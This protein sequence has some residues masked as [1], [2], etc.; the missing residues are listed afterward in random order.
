MAE[1]ELTPEAL[2]EKWE[3][4]RRD[5]GV[6]DAPSPAPAATTSEPTSNEASAVCVDCGERFTYESVRGFT[7]RPLFRRN[8]CDSCSEA[9]EQREQQELRDA[10]IAAANREAEEHQRA[11]AKRRATVLDLLE[12]CGV[13]TREHGGAAL[14][15]FDTSES[16]DEPVAAARAFLADVR[17]AGRHDPVRGL[18]LWGPTGAGKSTLAVAVLRELLL[19][20]SQRTDRMLFDHAAE[21]IAR[22]QGTY[23]GSG[24]T[25]DVLDRRSDAYLWILDDLGTER[26]SEDVMRHLTLI[27]TRRALR[28]T[29]VTSNL[30]PRHLDAERP[31]LSRVLSRLGP[32]YFRVVSVRGSDRRFG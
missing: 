14:E 27:F 30:S 17:A 1:T 23:G 7:G 8:R 25:F 19:D 9:E 18:Y 11:V 12:T 29:I 10:E 22:I 21:L 28:P 24:D 16:G 31:E 6:Q 26:S 2:L 5:L 32:R 15:A 3:Q 20:P 4:K 13:N